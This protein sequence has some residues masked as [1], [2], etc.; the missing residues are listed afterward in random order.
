[1]PI[2]ALMIAGDIDAGAPVLGVPLCEFQ[3][4]RAVAAGARHI[5]VL[6]ERIS[7]DL[8]AATDRLR[9]DGIGV[10]IAR[11]LGDAIDYVHPDDRVLLIGIRCFVDHDMLTT[12]A[13]AGAPLVL[14][15]PVAHAAPSWEIVDGTRRWTGWAAFDSTALRQ[16]GAMVG[17]WELAPTVLRYLLQNGAQMVAA[18]A[19]VVAPLDRAADREALGRRLL[20]VVGGSATGAGGHWMVRPVAR[21]LA[22]LAG[23]RGLRSLWLEGVALVIAAAAVVMAMFGLVSIAALLAVATHLCAGTGEVLRRAVD[24]A[25]RTRRALIWAVGGTTA[26]VIVLAG[27]TETAATGQW[28]CALLAFIIVIMLALT[29]SFAITPEDSAWLAD[30]PSALLLLVLGGTLGAPLGALGGVALH[31]TASVAWCRWRAHEKISSLASN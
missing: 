7:A 24:S 5:V 6:V 28:G 30:A 1:M 26:V 19:E 11:N 12:L 31:A 14:T 20:A 10:D 8:L 22:G 27:V 17:D 18:D 13:D 29:G 21:L 16:V 4:R 15:A 2:T 23:E 25:A 3:I 9:R